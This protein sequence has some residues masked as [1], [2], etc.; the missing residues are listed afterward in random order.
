MFLLSQHRFHLII[1]ILLLVCSSGLWAQLQVYP[2]ETMYSGI[3]GVNGDSVS[4]WEDADRFVNDSLFMSGTAD[5]RST[6]PSDYTGASGSWNV[7]LN[8]FQEYFQIDSMDC[9][10]Y[11]GI[12]LSL[13]IRKPS[14]AEDGSS[15]L[16]EYSYEGLNW[17]A[18]TYSLPTGAGT[19]GWHYITTSAV[20][21][22]SPLFSLRFTSLSN[23]DFRIDDILLQGL[24]SCPGEISSFFPLSGPSGTQVFIHG[25]GLANTTAVL[26]N[27]TPTPEFQVL[28]DSLVLAHVP[29][30]CGP[31]LVKLSSN[32]IIFSSIPFTQIDTSCALNGTNLIISELCDP[33]EFYSTDR[34]IEIFNPCSQEINLQGWSIRAISNFSEC[35]TWNLGGWIQPGQAMTCGYSSMVFGGIH[36]FTLANWNAGIPGSCCNSWNGNR[37]DGAALYS[38]SQLIDRALAENSLSPWF[39]DGCIQRDEPLCS[40][41]T[42]I[43][44]TGWI[45]SQEVLHAGDPPSSPGSHVTKCPGSA[46]NLSQQ[47]ISQLVCASG[48]A[49]FHVETETSEPPCSF[50]WL[51]LANDGSWLEVVEDSSFMIDGGS[52]FSNLIV[53][54]LPGINPGMQFYCKVQLDEG[55]CW[56]ASNACSLTIIS[57]PPTS[58]IYHY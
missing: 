52:N 11:S 14:N 50:T 18:V 40:P 22:P 45:I 43:S 31:G 5:M 46:P 37:R 12:T 58:D 9:S 49:V 32:C 27:Q 29:S 24:P 42:L 23:L 56:R 1:M 20:L 25:S 55:G 4:V 57:I 21:E 7:M 44:P 16:I 19:T 53:S 33:V 10:G 34:Y 6:Y 8:A 54:N 2:R 28:S 3:G 15:L 41:D 26:F 36:D 51:F 30:G 13:G 35:E 48:S 17:Y 39:A 38:G 47:P